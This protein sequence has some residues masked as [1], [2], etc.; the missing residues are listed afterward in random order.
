M[1][2]GKIYAMILGFVIIAGIFSITPN[3]FGGGSQELCFDENFEV[4]SCDDPTC[5]IAEVGQCIIPDDDEDGILNE[6]DN[7][8]FI[9]NP[10]QEDADS[11]GLG[12][13]CDLFPF[14][15]LNDVDG[16]GIG[17]DVDNCPVDFNPGQEDADRNGIGNAC[18][19][20]DRDMVLDILDNCPFI[21]NPDQVDIDP[22]N[23]IG[24]ACENTDLLVDAT[25]PPGDTINVVLPEEPSTGTFSTSLKLPPNVGG[26]VLIKKTDAGVTP[27]NF[28]FLGSVIDFNAPCSNICELSFNFTQASLDVQTITCEE[29]TI[30]HDMDHDGSFNAT[31]TI[32]TTVNCSD[33][34]P[35][36][37]TASAN[38][39]SK[40]SVGGIK[41]LA[42]GALGGGSGYKGGN[43]PTLENLSF[44]GVRTVNEDGTIGFGGLIIDEISSV[45]NFPTQTFETGV[46]SQLRFPFF[47]DNGADAIEHVAVYVLHEG[48]QSVY[49]S[50]LYLVYDKYKPLQTF[51]S[52]GYISDFTVSVN[53]KTLRE[54]DII[55]GITFAIPMEKSDIIV[56]TWDKYKRSIDYKFNQ[57]IQ[58]VES[59]SS[60]ELIENTE[61]TSQTN[62]I[63]NN[64]EKFS[65]NNEIDIPLWIKYNANWW[66][67][68][69]I[70]DEDFIAGIQ[71][72]IE[73]DIIEISESAK[74]QSDAVG[75][76]PAWI[77]SNAGWWAND[78]VSNGEFVSS[79]QWLIEKGVMEV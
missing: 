45:N 74:I 69:E 55:F 64:S 76:I 61:L 5:F 17:G 60:D 6:D 35:F 58:V 27:A 11:D 63:N 43:P 7:C 16:D 78:I 3:S 75:E 14:D 73:Q 72:L 4:V 57:L 62:T 49:D 50:D 32:D 68:E 46:P 29:V 77:K 12:D 18:Q 22:E 56:R 41:A 53:E 54:V 67:Q 20:V 42:L 13:V 47:E 34:E 15:P 10:G 51:D 79:I 28:S 25:F 1:N 30:F 31:E 40:F 33:P 59:D 52:N 23:G 26:P 44:D 70:G 19:D 2:L 21:P 48:D 66:S 38:F 37:A 8:Q 9:P 65:E 71:Y 39:T 36:T 24:D